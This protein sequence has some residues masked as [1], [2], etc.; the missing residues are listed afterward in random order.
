VPNQ[1]RDLAVTVARYHTICHRVRSLTAATLLQTLESLDAFRRPERFEEF[2]LCCEADA[3]GRTGLE[4]RDYSQVDYFREALRVA[5]SIGAK[6]VD[7]S[8]FKGKAFG[9]ELQR[10]RTAALAELTPDPA[11][12]APA[13]RQS[14]NNGE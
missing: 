13:A 11:D 3:R 5:N 7:G 2:L 9:E 10:L 14:T 6:D 8:K 1:H 4:N 12:Q